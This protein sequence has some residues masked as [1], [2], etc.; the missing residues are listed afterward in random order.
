MDVCDKILTSFGARG[1]SALAFSGG[2]V[3]Q[4]DDDPSQCLFIN[5]RSASETGGCHN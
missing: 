3:M 5:C 4:V 1:T 2:I